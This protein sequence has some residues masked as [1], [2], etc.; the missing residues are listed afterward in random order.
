M[1][2]RFTHLRD[3]E[4]GMSYLWVGLGFMAFFSATTLAI[5]VGMFMTARSQAQNSADA[6]ALAGAT[7]LV[8]DDFDDRSATGP[9]VTSAINT[10]KGNDVMRSDVSVTPADVTFPVSPSGASDRV[11]VRVFR[12]GDRSNPVA[13]LIGPIFGVPTVDIGATATAEAALA[14]AQSCVK[15]FTI[16][17]RWQENTHPNWDPDDEFQKY[18]NHGNLLLNRDV[19]NPPGSGTYYGYD[20]TRDKGLQLMLRAGTGEQ[21]N[22]SFYF[23]W[24]MPGGSGGDFY[25]ENIAGCNTTLMHPGDLIT[26]EPGNMVGPTVQGIDDLIAKDPSAYWSDGYN[27]VMSTM[28][29]SPRVIAIPLY[30]PDYYAEGKANGRNA[31]LRVANWMG[32][33]VTGRSGNNVYGRITPILGIYDENAGPAPSGIFPKVIRLVE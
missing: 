17:D 27:K 12:T 31:D 25:R 4:R 11:R 10:A 6:G 2:N 14:N 20:S 3:D 28:S 26:A 16:P 5:D 8:Y 30:D 7:A 23:S 21:I 33:F 32:F 24:A 22:P 29:P 1:A 15:P 19:Y 13:T 18:D 9:A